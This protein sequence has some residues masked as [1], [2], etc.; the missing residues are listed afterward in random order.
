MAHESMVTGA[1]SEH[2]AA[3]ALLNAGYEVSKPVLPEVYDFSI[4]DPLN[5]NHYRVQVKTLRIRADRDNALVVMAKKGNGE[6]YTTEDT[7]YIIGVDL[8][9]Q[10]C[11][12][13]ECRGCSEYWSTEETAKTRWISLDIFESN[14][15]EAV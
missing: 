13:F 2:F 1:L 10:R 3:I 11:Y 6:A 4:R 8:V 5:G 15:S 7:D 12:M 9:N 14:E